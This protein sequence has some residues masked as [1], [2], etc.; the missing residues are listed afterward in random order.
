M[1][2]LAL[3][4]TLVGFVLLVLGLIT[5]QVWLAVA[6]IV[7]CL[8]GLAFLLVDVIG[9]G[10]RGSRSIEEMV[11]GAGDDEPD[12]DDRDGGE[13]REPH[14]SDRGDSHPVESEPDVA[15]PGTAG[16]RGDERTD[17]G[18]HAALPAEPSPEPPREG[19]LQDYLRSVG[20]ELPPQRTPPPPPRPAGGYGP[21]PGARPPGNRS[22][23]PQM[24]PMSPGSAPRRPEQ[25]QPKPKFDPLDPNWRPPLD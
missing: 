7:I 2:T 16:I 18:R 12:Q 5:G 1:L 23:P 13:S 24:P 14:D 11:P 6:C 19:G 4:A 22:G 15:S 25:P 17:S 10:R 3:A 21:P 20:G 9:S 8:V